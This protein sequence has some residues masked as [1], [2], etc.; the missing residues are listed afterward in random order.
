MIRRLL[1]STGSSAGMLTAASLFNSIVAILGGILTAK[2][3]LPEE[4]GQ[5]NLLSIFTS[6]IILVQIGIPS[7][8]SRELPF[9]FGKNN[10]R[11]AESLAATSKFFMLY[12]SLAILVLALIASGYF[13]MI[14]NFE[15][16]VGCIVVGATTFQ[17][18]YT[19]KYLKVLYRS[20]NHFNKLAK[21]TV[22]DAVVSVLSIYLVYRFHFYGLC[23]RA[24][25]SSIVSWYFSE[26]W[27]P[28]AVNS[29]WSYSNFKEL[30]KVGMP[31]YFVANI[32]GL[33]PTFQR[34]MIVS[35]LGTKA[36]GL[37]SL[38]TIV[39]GVL[40]TLS[41]SISSVIFPKMATAYGGGASVLELL[42]IPAKFVLMVF[43]VN[44]VLLV[45]GWNLLPIVVTNFLP[46]Y[47]AGIEAAQWMLIVA[48]INSF[49]IFSSIYMVLKKNHLRLISYCLGMV[50]W[51]LFINFHNIK[52]EAD[53]VVYSKALFYGFVTIAVID[54][55][56]Y[57]FLWK[58]DIANKD[59]N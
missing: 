17:G 34:T 13:L 22:I 38:A 36:L 16:A 31:I 43:I 51:Y 21:I 52:G 47:V 8:L 53:L 58:K 26:K 41:G 55:F 24:I 46:N 23:A 48:V 7:G 4:L 1:G 20:E 5:F 42:K 59:I 6:Y 3:L 19:T 9:Y 39:Q 30:S 40:N 50:V 11:H 25:L 45:V 27:K 28:L 33:W 49:L 37:Y 35:L 12:L 57:Y 15:Y 10:Q 54:C 44:V 14:Q 18:L 56:M 2:W 32:Y 29:K